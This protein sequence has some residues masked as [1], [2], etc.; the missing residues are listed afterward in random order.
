MLTTRKTLEDSPEATETGPLKKPSTPLD[1]VLL[2]GTHGLSKADCETE[3][4]PWKKW[5]SMISPMGT[6]TSLG[7]MTCPPLP[8]SM[9]VTPF[10][11]CAA[12]WVV[13]ELDELDEPEVSLP[14]E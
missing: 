6:V 3:W 9:R 8:T 14:Y 1:A 12:D 4:A 10:W 7:L 11:V 2:M 5:N 13:P